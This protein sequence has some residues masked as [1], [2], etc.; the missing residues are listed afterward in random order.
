MLCVSSPEPLPLL[1]K[2]LAKLLDDDSDIGSESFE[3]KI[4]D[5]EE[6]FGLHPH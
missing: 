5:Q 3:L 6:R 4:L 2:V 1:S